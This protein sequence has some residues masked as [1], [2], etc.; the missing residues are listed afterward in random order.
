M[1]K[2]YSRNMSLKP[3]NSGSASPRRFEAGFSNQTA[4]I[5][6][7]LCYP[8]GLTGMALLIS[9]GNQSSGTWAPP[10]LTSATTQQSISEQEARSVIQAWWNVRPRVFAS[11]YDVSE[12]S[13]VVAAG[14]LWTD[15]NKSD[16]P[17]AWL[18]NHNQ[19]YTYQGTSIESVISFDPQQ[20]DRPSMVVNVSTRDTLHGP[21]VYKPSSSTANYRYIFA[22]ESGRWK[23]WNYE[24]I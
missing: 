6:I 3:R 9:A 18:R 11:P 24:K 10:A 17:V 16:G 19:Y 1:T 15:L 13:S 12:A 21:G 22:K 14:P 8:L 4:L 2:P 7:A 5:L 20:G 23:I